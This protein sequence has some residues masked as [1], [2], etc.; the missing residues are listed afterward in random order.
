MTLDVA[1]AYEHYAA[2]IR[3]YCRDRAGDAGD[4][5]AGQVWVKVVERAHTYE[6]RG[7]LRA[8]L[9]YIAT[10]KIID[11]WRSESR[12]PRFMSLDEY[13]RVVEFDEPCDLA[14]LLVAPLTE[15]QRVVLLHRIAGY[16]NR[17][18]AER[19]GVHIDTVKAT[20]WRARQKVAA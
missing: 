8:W 18:T 19:L 5:I 9:F 11:H 7:Q 4:D 10:M 3:R 12:R 20:L 13:S 17:E 6:E 15:N 16:G 1:A 2:D 14:D